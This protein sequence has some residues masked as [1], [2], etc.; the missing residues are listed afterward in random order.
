MRRTDL[1][2]RPKRSMVTPVSALGLTAFFAEAFEID[3]C[4]R[5][6][7]PLCSV[8]MASIEIRR[9][10]GNATLAGADRAGG[11]SGMWRA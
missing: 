3:P 4:R 10:R 11:G 8:A 6:Q 9:P 2:T 7:L 1:C 5:D